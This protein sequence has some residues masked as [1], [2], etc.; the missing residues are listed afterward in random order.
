[1]KATAYQR[2]QS[3]SVNQGSAGA[4]VRHRSISS[5]PAPASSDQHNHA[6]QCTVALAS[7]GQ[8]WGP[9]L[10]PSGRFLGA[11]PL[12]RTSPNT[13]KV[14]GSGEEPDLEAEAEA[15]LEQ[16]LEEAGTPEP[17]DGSSPSLAASQATLQ[18]SLQST[19]QLILVL[20]PDLRAQLLQRAKNEVALRAVQD[21]LTKLSVSLAGLDRQEVEITALFTGIMSRGVDVEA[22][23][24]PLRNAL[25][26]TLWDF[27]SQCRILNQASTTLAD[28]V[29]RELQAYRHQYHEKNRTALRQLVCA[30]AA[31]D[32]FG[33]KLIVLRSAL[34]GNL[35][36]LL[37]RY[38]SLVHVPLPALQELLEGAWPATWGKTGRRLVPGTLDG[39]MAGDMALI[40]HLIGEHH[41]T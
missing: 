2:A 33:Q 6:Q 24:R 40:E 11:T 26:R 20:L 21:T 39:D 10:G 37:L 19:L 13:S 36:E 14:H 9:A 27:F 7:S 12:R 28:P 17:G 29:M 16:A 15:A 23:E 5:R 31:D 4:C 3:P 18:S 34:R 38:P 8:A 35:S 22:E 41:L 25:V 1:M 30:A 32:S